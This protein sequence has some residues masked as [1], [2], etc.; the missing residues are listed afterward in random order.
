MF[1]L[2]TKVHF[3]LSVKCLGIAQS[4]VGKTKANSETGSAELDTFL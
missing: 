4:N 1:F 3:K 2:A